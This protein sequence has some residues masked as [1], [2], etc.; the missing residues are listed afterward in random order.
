MDLFFAKVSFV[1]F[2]SN[3]IYY[4]QTPLYLITGYG[5]LL[6]LAYCYYVSAKEFN[7][8]DHW[9]KYH[10]LFHLILAYE[11]CIILDSIVQSRQPL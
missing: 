4:V 11:Q 1:V 8:N 10:V 2:I 5:G 7:T 3:G 9:Y 6:L